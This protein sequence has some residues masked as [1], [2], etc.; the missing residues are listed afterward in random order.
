MDGRRSE[1]FPANDLTGRTERPTN[2]F[3]VLLKVALLW[4][5]GAHPHPAIQSQQMAGG[6]AEPQRVRRSP[7]FSPPFGILTAIW[8]IFRKARLDSTA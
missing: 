6:R 2:Q 1:P 5:G 3:D 4:G 7:C 8:K